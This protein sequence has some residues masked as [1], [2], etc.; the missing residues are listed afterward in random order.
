M[1]NQKRFETVKFTIAQSVKVQELIKQHICFIEEKGV[2]SFNAEE[3]VM[4]RE[5]LKAFSA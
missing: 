1:A 4:L 2:D 5:M 3:Y